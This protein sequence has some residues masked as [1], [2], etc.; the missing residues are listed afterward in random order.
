MA[1]YAVTHIFTDHYCHTI[2][3]MCGHSRLQPVHAVIPRLPL[4]LRSLLFWLCSCS[5]PAQVTAADLFLLLTC[6]CCWPT[7]VGNLY[8]VHLLFQLLLLPFCVTVHS[9]SHYRADMFL[10]RSFSMQV[11]TAFLS[12]CSDYYCWFAWATTF[13][14]SPLFYFS[15]A[16]VHSLFK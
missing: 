5:F 16:D 13:L 10:H 7:P 12:L 2:E 11:Y 15:C 1:E 8:T 4:L 6:Y 9:C 3:H 14:R